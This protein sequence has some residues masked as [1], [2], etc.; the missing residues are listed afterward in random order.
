MH[1][2]ECIHFMMGVSISSGSYDPF[3]IPTWPTSV[4]FDQQGVDSHHAYDR[5]RTFKNGG[6]YFFRII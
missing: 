4:P 3:G 5:M 6:E 2:I 1:M